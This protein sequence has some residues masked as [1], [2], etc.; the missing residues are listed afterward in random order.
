[1]KLKKKNKKVG[2]RNTDNN[3]VVKKNISESR[4]IFLQKLWKG[5]GVLVS[6]EF[7]AVIIGFLFSGKSSE[8]E[9][10]PKQLIEAG[11]ANSFY[12]GT[13]THFRGGR[14]YLARLADGGFIAMSIRC[15]HLGCSVIWEDDKKRFVCPCHAS[16]FLINGEV[17]NP[18]APKA[19]DYY[20]VMIENGNVKVDVGTR[21]ERSRFN[22]DQVVY[23]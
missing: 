15:T 13:V 6:V 12:P 10:K 2:D 5:L 16:V 3:S 21:L 17:Q 20:P 7:L 1:M 9:S 8:N 19:L 4:R 23:I 11:N 22:K 18:P 14:F